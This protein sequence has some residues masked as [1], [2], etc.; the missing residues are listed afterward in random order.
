V[1]GDDLAGG[2]GQGMFGTAGAQGGAMKL[3]PVLKGMLA[4]GGG[5][6][7]A[8]GLPGLLDA[9]HGAGLG[10]KA[11]S[12]VGT[13][14][15][16][17]LHPDEVQQALGAGAVQEI[18]DRAQLSTDET[19]HGL[20]QLLPELVDRLTPD[21]AVPEGGVGDRLGSVLGGLGR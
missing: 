14:A 1:G 19:E 6:G 10:H 15:N 12:W 13:G 21:G 4:G 7:P 9:F 2:L 16:E 8:G 11:R 20:A 3:L 18:A 17:D 5:P